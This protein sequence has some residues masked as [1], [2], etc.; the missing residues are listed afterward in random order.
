VSDPF[1]TSVSSA[2]HPERVTDSSNAPTANPLDRYRTNADGFSARVAAVAADDPRW[3]SP[4]PCAGWTARD[5]VRH[6]VEAHSIFYGLVEHDPGVEP[7]SVDDDPATAWEAARA[8]M[9]AALGDPDVAG[10]EFDGTFGP[11]T[12]ATS[13]DRFL[14]GDVL[15][16]TWD[17]SRALGLDDTLDA[18]AVRRMLAE[19][20][21]LDPAVEARMRRPD[22]YGPAV[23]VAADAS[24]QDRLI[25]F[26]G[27]DPRVGAA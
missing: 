20:A 16:H 22:V 4:A 26:T 23:D 24:G 10:R 17:L 1:K 5:V 9:E 21:A 13:I 2:A 19:Y 11:T 25:A 3:N 18:G 15:I 14:T 8:A 12:F 7:A 6:L 27:R